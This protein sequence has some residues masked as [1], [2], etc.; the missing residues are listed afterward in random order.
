MKLTVGELAADIALLP[1]SVAV[2]S[3]ILL[4][5]GEPHI[6]PSGNK[7]FQRVL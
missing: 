3:Q 4:S 7:T 6:Q 5:I 1:C 2:A